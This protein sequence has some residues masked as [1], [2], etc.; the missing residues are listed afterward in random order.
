MEL[1]CGF[2]MYYSQFNFSTYSI[3]IHESHLIGRQ[4]NYYR[5][6]HEKPVFICCPV[7]GENPARSLIPDN[8]KLFHKT[9]REFCQT[10]LLLKPEYSEKQEKKLI[11][12]MGLDF[13]SH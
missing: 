11:K 12:L 10:I 1:F 8:F 6:G 2:M 5:D 3:N 13:T 9:V 4:R 7:G